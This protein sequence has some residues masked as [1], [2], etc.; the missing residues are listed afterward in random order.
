LLALIEKAGMQRQAAYELVQARALRSLEERQSFETL[1][2][3]DPEIA[4]R[5]NEGE[6]AGLFDPYYY[7]RHEEEIFQRVFGAKG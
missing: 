2:R 4:S 7:L 5:L 6:L 3:R 1:L